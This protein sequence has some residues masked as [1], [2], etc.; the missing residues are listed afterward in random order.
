MVRGNFPFQPPAG[1][2]TQPTSKPPSILRSQQSE[3]SYPDLS[4]MK[5]GL[6][7]AQRERDKAN[8]DRD[9]AKRF[10]IGIKPSD[11]AILERDKAILD[12]NLLMAERESEQRLKER[13]AICNQI[14]LE[15]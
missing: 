8:L 2:L 1:A 6:E 15:I 7:K 9:Q 5:R 3:E 10:S 14:K 11:Q 12:R 13:V 4:S